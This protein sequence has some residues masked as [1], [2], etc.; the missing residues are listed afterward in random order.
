MPDDENLVT[1]DENNDTTSGD[2]TTNTGDDSGGG[3]DTTNTGD[4]SGGT[5]SDDSGSGDDSGGGSTYDSDTGGGSTA[6]TINISVVNANTLDEL[7]EPSS[8]YSF[9]MVD[10][11]TNAGVLLDYNALAEAILSK[12]MSTSDTLPEDGIKFYFME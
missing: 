2:D 5:N 9:I 6:P 10:R 3:D 1:D 4:D 7:G 11:A 12:V 8:G